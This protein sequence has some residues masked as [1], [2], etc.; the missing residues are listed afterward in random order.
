MIDDKRT[1]RL[2]PFPM[3]AVLLIFF[4]L[5]LLVVIGW[6][7]IRLAEEQHER[8]SLRDLT[9]R[10]QQLGQTCAPSFYF[11]REWGTLFGELQRSAHLYDQQVKLVRDWSRRQN[12]EIEVYRLSA[13]GEVRVLTPELTR[14]Q[15]I[16]KDFWNFLRTGKEEYR[17]HFYAPPAVRALFGRVFAYDECFAHRGEVLEISHAGKTGFLYWNSSENPDGGGVIIV[18]WA[19]PGLPSLLDRFRDHI[20]GS[21]T[22]LVV[23]PADETLFLRQ[24]PTNALAAGTEVERYAWSSF[25]IDDVRVYAGIPRTRLRLSLERQLLAGFAATV[26]VLLLILLWRWNRGEQARFLSIRWKLAG[27]F[28]YAL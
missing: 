27:P 4:P 26:G 21:D 16:I 12:L 6:Y 3:Q 17:Y 5:A 23:Q 11:A 8:E 2:V 9:R 14:A 19:V 20:L 7:G 28:L 24:P 13:A 10:L 22:A 25:R 15:A 1:R 18:A